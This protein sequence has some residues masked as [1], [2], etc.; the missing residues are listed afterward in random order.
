M[1]YG[2]RFYFPQFRET[3]C[4]ND[5][6]KQKVHSCMLGIDATCIKDFEN[7]MCKSHGDL[8]SESHANQYGFFREINHHK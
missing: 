4:K 6:S 7:Q 1:I 3:L 2:F 8:Y 5:I